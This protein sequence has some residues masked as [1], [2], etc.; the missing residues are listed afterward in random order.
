LLVTCESENVASSHVIEK[1]GGAL[2]D[3][4]YV[5]SVDSIVRRYWISLS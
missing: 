4:T 2:E 5:A 1:C 3:E